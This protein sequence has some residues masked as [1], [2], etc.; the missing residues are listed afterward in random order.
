MSKFCYGKKIEQN[1]KIQNHIMFYLKWLHKIN[2]VVVVNRVLQGY[3]N[4]Q[5]NL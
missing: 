5:N 2:R 4:K 3:L 1:L